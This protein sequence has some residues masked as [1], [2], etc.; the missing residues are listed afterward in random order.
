MTKLFKENIIDLA[1]TPVHK[2][3]KSGSLD[4]LNSINDKK[5]KRS[6]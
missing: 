2:L 5:R 6:V 1:D 4:E 3:N